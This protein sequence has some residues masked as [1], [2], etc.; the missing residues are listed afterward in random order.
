MK[1][2]ILL[3]FGFLVFAFYE[4]SGGADFDPNE[5]REQRLAAY[6]AQT[7]MSANAAELNE[8]ELIDQDIVEASALV[9][10]E[11][12]NTVDTTP[13]VVLA[14]DPIETPTQAS[15]ETTD[16]ESAVA[17]ESLQPL[18]DAEAAAETNGGET[19][20]ET[21]LSVANAN[22]EDPVVV[23]PSLI[24]PTDSAAVDA[25]VT[26]AV[27][28]PILDVREVTGNRVNVRGG[29][30]TNFGIVG[31]LRQGDAVEILEDNGNGWVRMRAIEA[32]AE[33]WM[34]DFLL[35]DS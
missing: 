32:D 34:A 23:L 31:K 26:A 12:D 6:E 20:G 30:S 21:D 19:S 4:L 11:A 33:G 13:T 18:P 5:I 24:A 1:V 9:D 22:L 16:V 17:T 3:T 28:E 15:F 8:E 29:P 2:F 10:T 27:T 14:D 7:A 25:A 35:T